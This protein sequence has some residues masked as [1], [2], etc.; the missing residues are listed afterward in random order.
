MLARFFLENFCKENELP[1]K[2]M[3]RSEQKILLDY[4]FPGNVR[5]LRSMIE[6]S[7][8]MSNENEILPEDITLGSSDDSFNEEISRELTLREHTHK[9]VKSYLNNYD[10]NVKLVAKKLDVGF[11]TIYR[12]LK[13]M[14]ESHA[15]KQLN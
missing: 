1:L 12:M 14:E 11:S 3:S 6:L 4:S 10:N 9:I 15:E 8:V 7:A 5:E 13:E 2:V